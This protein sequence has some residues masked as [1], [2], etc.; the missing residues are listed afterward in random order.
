MTQINIP[1]GNNR[2][3]RQSDRRTDRRT[4][5]PRDPTRSLRSP[6]QAEPPQTVQAGKHRTEGSGW[7]SESQGERRRKTGEPWLP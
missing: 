1:A 7:G 2:I 4:E 6:R 5:P 3:F